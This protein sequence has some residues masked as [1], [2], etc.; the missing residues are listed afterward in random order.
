[1]SR[2]PKLNYNTHP[3]TI[4]N[5]PRELRDKVVKKTQQTIKNLKALMDNLFV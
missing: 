1:M 2:P 4:R 5:L 3:P